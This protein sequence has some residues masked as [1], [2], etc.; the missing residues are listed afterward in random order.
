MERQNPDSPQSA[1]I[2]GQFFHTFSDAGG[3]EYQGQILGRLEPGYYICQ[4]FEPL[5]GEPSCR[6][7]RHIAIMA[8]WK[9]YETAEDWLSAHRRDSDAGDR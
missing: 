3:L 2:I 1:N 9:Y 8:K 5:F 6:I 7:I 4:L